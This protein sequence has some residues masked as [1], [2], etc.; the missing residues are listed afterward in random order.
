MKP[1]YDFSDGV[2]G[3][4]SRRTG[5]ASRLIWLVPLGLV[6]WKRRKKFTSDPCRWSELWYA[7]DDVLI[8]M[9]RRKRDV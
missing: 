8:E 5:W 6:L 7:D 2:R 1:K 3:K 4:Y 9:R